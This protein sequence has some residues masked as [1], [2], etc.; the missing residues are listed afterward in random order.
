M[1]YNG[2][3][4]LASSLPG[5]MWNRAESE[6]LV[7]G[8]NDFLPPDVNVAKHE[9]TQLTELWR[10]FLLYVIIFIKRVLCGMI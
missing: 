2:K 5:T 4:V 7:Y 8:P 9:A 1:L 10:I 6:S 3:E